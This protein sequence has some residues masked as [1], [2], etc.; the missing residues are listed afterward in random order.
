MLFRSV[1]TVINTKAPLAVAAC[2][3]AANTLYDKTKDGYANEIYAF[4]EC[5]DTKDRKEG[6]S[7]FLE[8]RKA[9]FTG[10]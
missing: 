4:G 6:S 1:L 9:D 7:A 8:K 5:F 3:Q 10:K 2:M